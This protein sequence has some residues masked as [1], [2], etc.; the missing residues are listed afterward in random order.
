[1]GGPQSPATTTEECP[2]FFAEKEIQFIKTA[3]QADI[4]VLGV[5][6]GAQLIGEALGMEFEHSPNREIGVFDVEL[7]EKA[8]QDPIFSSFPKVFPVA[9]W[10]GDMPGVTDSA[11]IFAKSEGCPRQIVK[12]SPKVYGFQCHFEFDDACVAAMSE[13]CG[14]ELKKYSEK[15]YIWTAEQLKNYNYNEINAKLFTFLDK[16]TQK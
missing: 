9:H 14:H 2:H 4:I 6:L 10:H 5:C 8:A 1:M 12:Y 7:T 11:E 16:I 13:N 15:P 3:I